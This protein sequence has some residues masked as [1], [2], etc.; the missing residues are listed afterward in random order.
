MVSYLT[1]YQLRKTK[2]IF[3]GRTRWHDLQSVFPSHQLGFDRTSKV[4]AITER[5][6]RVGSIRICTVHGLSSAKLQSVSILSHGARLGRDCTDW[7]LPTIAELPG[8][9]DR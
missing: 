9:F 5:K 6:T 8:I 7:R 1:E 3:A 4:A 2:C